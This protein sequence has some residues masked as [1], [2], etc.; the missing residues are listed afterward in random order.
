MTRLQG[1]NLAWPYDLREYRENKGGEEFP[2]FLLLEW[3]RV[4]LKKKGNFVFVYKNVSPQLSYMLSLSYILS[5]VLFTFQ[6]NFYFIQ[7]FTP[8]N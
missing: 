1:A 6:C 5:F 2:S 8:I 7:V 3:C 4:L